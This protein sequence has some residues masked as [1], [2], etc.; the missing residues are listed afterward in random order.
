MKS[1]LLAGSL[2]CVLAATPALAQS[3]DSPE[4]LAEITRDIA[5]FAAATGIDITDIRFDIG[6]G[7]P[8]STPGNAGCTVPATVN[9][10][11]GTAL[12]VSATAATCADAW[13]MIRQMLDDMA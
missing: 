1:I 10:P 2:A 11:A 4:T 7:A 5:H 13:D 12:T 6:T 9:T 3:Q 8:A